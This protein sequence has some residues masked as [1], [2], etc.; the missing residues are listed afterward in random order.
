MNGIRDVPKGTRRHCMVAS[1]EGVFIYGGSCGC[2]SVDSNG[3]Q[4]DVYY[5]DFVHFFDPFEMLKSELYVD[6]IFTISE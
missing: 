4:T 2:Q 3:Q 5:M 6:V 1:N